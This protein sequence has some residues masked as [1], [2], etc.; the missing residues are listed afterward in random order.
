MPHIKFI[1]HDGSEH[2]VE[3]TIGTTLCQAA[4]DNFVPGILGDCGCNCT[5]GTCHG[6]IDQAWL[7]TLPPMS[8]EESGILEGVLNPCEN[9]R[10]LCQIRIEPEL[11]GLVVNLP[12]SQF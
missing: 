3:A 7:A 10:L 4:L 9:S 5:C 2:S 6:Y 11:D 12:A 8:K 1:Q